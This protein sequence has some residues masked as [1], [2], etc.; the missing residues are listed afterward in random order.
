[1]TLGH[2]MFAA[3]M[4]L[5]MGAAAIIEERD[6]ESHFGAL[7]RDYQQRVPMFIPRLGPERE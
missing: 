5:Y 3:A 4:T 2:W 7:Y 1:M 6:L